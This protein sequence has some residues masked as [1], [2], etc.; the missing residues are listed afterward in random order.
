MPAR[1]D[2]GLGQAQREAAYPTAWPIGNAGDWPTNFDGSPI[3][4]DMERGRAE[5]QRWTA[6]TR[7]HAGVVTEL[8]TPGRVRDAS[9]A[10]PG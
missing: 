8:M 4:T 1:G 5:G 2:L 9:G 3:R 10:V 7:G 6:R